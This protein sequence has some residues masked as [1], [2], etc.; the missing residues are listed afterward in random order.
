MPGPEM[1]WWLL[2]ANVFRHIDVIFGASMADASMA[3]ICP[4]S[5]AV[6][7][8]GL[9]EHMSH[10]SLNSSDGE[11]FQPKVTLTTWPTY[12]F[13]FSAVV[14]MTICMLALMWVSKIIRNQSSALA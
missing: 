1:P 4:K 14:A 9:E 5:T 7:D 13:P 3:S 12:S 6:F 2:G 10:A 8:S 11:Q